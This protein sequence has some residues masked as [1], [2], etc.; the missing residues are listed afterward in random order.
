MAGHE[1]KNRNIPV[2]GS[3]VSTAPTSGEEASGERVPLGQGFGVSALGKH[4]LSK[5]K[6]GKLPVALLLL[7]FLMALAILF[8][9]LLSTTDVL[10]SDY[11]RLVNSYLGKPFQLGDLLQKDILT[12]IPLT[13]FFREI[14]RHSFG[15]TLIF[16]RALGV[17]GL[18]LAS[19]PLLLFMRKKQL[20]FSQQLLFLL[21]FYSLN[22]WEML[23][24]G[25]GYIHFLAFSAFYDYF[26]ALDQAFSKKSSLLVLSIYPPFILLVAGPYCL[27][28]FLSCFALF[29]FL[30]LGKKLWD[31]KGTILLLISNGLC[32]FLY[33]LSNHYAVYEYAG[34]ESISLREVLQNHLLFVVKFIFYG[35]SSMLVSGE[36]LE[37]LLRDGVIQGKGIVLIGAFVLFFYI[38]MTLLYLWK[39]FASSGNGGGKVFSKKNDGAPSLNQ[40]QKEAVNPIEKNPMA[41]E[42]GGES[43]YFGLLPGLL[44][45]HGLASHALVFLTRYMFLKESYA[46]QS[47]YA[48]Q[49]QSAL[50]GAFLLLFLW[51]NENR[52]SLGQKARTAQGRLAVCLLF[53]GI[54]LLGTLWTDRSEWG[55]SMYRRE[56]YERMW[57]YSHDLSAYSDEELEDVFEYRHGGERI[58]KAFAIWEQVKKDWR[59]RR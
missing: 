7:S 25:S 17:L 49:Y 10:Y 23:L 54:F 44:L 14:N 12:R 42:K 59:E 57:S 39:F 6:E 35:F 55:K 36:N 13:Y 41:A 8:Y 38:F 47:R 11:I 22:K 43:F 30:A 2:A 18:F 15:Y 21:L 48:L 16:D 1:G 51:K 19:K 56:H 9:V 40:G 26:Y 31:M 27:A 3:E 5:G 45:L 53:S 52:A 20:S 29:F 34:A 4:L 50:L 24:N 46:F 28:V 37:K 32:L 33:L 58:R